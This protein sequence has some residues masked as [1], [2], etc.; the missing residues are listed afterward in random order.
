MSTGSDF[1]K[2][3]RLKLWLYRIIDWI[4][5][6]MPVIVYVVIALCD[7]GVTTVGKVSVV[8]TVAVAAILAL[9]NII[10]Q[11]RLRCPIW[12]V[13]IGLYIA[14]RDYLLPL[15]I[16]LAVVSICDDLILTPLIS[17]YRSKL[18][19]NK[20]IDERLGPDGDVQSK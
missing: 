4:L 1:T 13:L 8:G 18:I 14:I 10:A 9:F 6:F 19:A 20:A 5:L 16:I 15:V 3:C 11:K 12:I 17:Y 2:V 7:E